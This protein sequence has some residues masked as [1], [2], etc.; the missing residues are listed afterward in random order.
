M[1]KFGDDIVSICSS[2]L[3]RPPPDALAVSAPAPAR[4]AATQ[5]LPSSDLGAALKAFRTRRANE[6]STPPYCVF[7]NA[8]LDALVA[9]CPRSTAELSRIKGFGASKVSKFGDDIV[10]IC[11]SGLSRP[12]PNA[13]AAAAAATATGS[14]VP[15]AKRR[16]PS[17]FEASAQPAPPPA[18]RIDRSALNAEQL[19][20]AQ[21]IL[22]GQN[23]FLTGAAG[24]GK[25]YLLRYVIQQLESAWPAPGAVPVVAPTGI[26]ASHVQGVTIHSW[27]GIGLGKGSPAALCD[28]V[29]GNGAAVERWRRARCLV[30]DEV[31]MLDSGILDA[32]DRIGRNA[33]GEIARAFGGLQLV[34]CGRPNIDLVEVRASA[35]YENGLSEGQSVVKWFWEMLKD[36][37]PEERSLFLTFVTGAPRIPLDGLDPPLKISGNEMGE[38]SLPRS[39]TC[40]NRLDLPTYS[41]EA[42]LRTVLTNVIAVDIEGFSMQ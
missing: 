31:S 41:S 33:R 12:P 25:S 23:V 9:A 38:G 35:V 28:K 7:T 17:S 6:L 15:P 18:A 1:S 27:A 40:F 19:G 30:I 39:H 36:M 21:R 37:T 2:G 3:S 16:L 22:G 42:Q 24:V 29:L 4:P 20:A 13:L 34:L 10:S 32:L 11:S 5:A 8:E 14:A 26:A